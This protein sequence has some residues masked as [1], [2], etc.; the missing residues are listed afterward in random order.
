M[1]KL[2]EYQI[3]Y[4]IIVHSHLNNSQKDRELAQLMSS[5]EKEFS[6]PAL[7][8][9]EWEKKNKKVISLYRKISLSRNFE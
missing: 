1:S 2:I 7:R 4:E 9:E 6:I 3:E 5:M 8:N